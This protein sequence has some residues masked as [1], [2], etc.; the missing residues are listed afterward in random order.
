MLVQIDDIILM[1]LVLHYEVI[2]VFEALLGQG[3]QGPCRTGAPPLAL[4]TTERTVA[5]LGSDMKNAAYGPGGCTRRLLD[6]LRDRQ[7]DVVTLQKIGLEKDF[8]TQALH[9]IGYESKSLG[10][11]SRSTSELPY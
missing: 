10:R 5:I 8:P 3:D 7:P 4:A 1:V 2:V 6:W 11:R 9:E